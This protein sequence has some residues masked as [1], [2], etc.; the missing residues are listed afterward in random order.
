MQAVALFAEMLNFRDETLFCNSLFSECVFVSIGVFSA[1]YF[2]MQLLIYNLNA[3]SIFI[4]A[5]N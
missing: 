2:G 3:V 5:F 4:F 1:P